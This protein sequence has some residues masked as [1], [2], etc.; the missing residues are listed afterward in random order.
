MLVRFRSTSR[1]IFKQ[2]DMTNG[3]TPAD[4]F[5]FRNHDFHADSHADIH[6]D[7]GGFWPY[8]IAGWWLVVGLCSFYF[9]ILLGLGLRVHMSPPLIRWG[10]VSPQHLTLG[11]PKVLNVDR[12]KQ[13]ILFFVRCM[14]IRAGQE[15]WFWHVKNNMINFRKWPVCIDCDST[16]RQPMRMVDCHHQ[17]IGYLASSPKIVLW[18]IWLCTSCFRGHSPNAAAWFFKLLRGLIGIIWRTLLMFT[19]MLEDA[20]LNLPGGGGVGDRNN[21]HNTTLRQRRNVRNM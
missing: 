17:K 18:Y 9:L 15:P 2:T 8:M 14:T 4:W 3:Q 11:I 5:M 7:L 10:M 13:L 12:W 20:G 1:Y 19:R 6:Q 16:P 21:M